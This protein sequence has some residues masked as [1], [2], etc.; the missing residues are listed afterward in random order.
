MEKP[1]NGKGDSPRSCF[2]RDF[3]NNYDKIDWSVDKNHKRCYDCGSLIDLSRVDFYEVFEDGNV[4]HK[5]C[6]FN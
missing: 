4:R 1:K 5:Q 3:K 2:S 6:N